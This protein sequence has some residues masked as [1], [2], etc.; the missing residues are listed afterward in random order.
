MLRNDTRTILPEEEDE[1]DDEEAE[2]PPMGL[3]SI[4]ILKEEERKIERDRSPMRLF[5]DNFT[6][7]HFSPAI[8][9]LHSLI[10]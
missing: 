1:E 2:A 10:K 5:N 7:L 3:L 9:D 6:Q 4:T 8:V